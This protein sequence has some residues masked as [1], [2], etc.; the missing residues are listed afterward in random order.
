M[1]RHEKQIVST[2]VGSGF[3][4]GPVIEARDAFEKAL[5]LTVRTAPIPEHPADAANRL[6]E[7]L[8]SGGAVDISA[9]ALEITTAQQS[10]EAARLASEIRAC[11]VDAVGDRVVSVLR[12]EANAVHAAARARFDEVTS[13]ARKIALEL[14]AAGIGSIT[15]YAAVRDGSATVRRG[16]KRFEEELAREIVSCRDV[17][18][19]LARL[20][21][22]TIERDIDRVFECFRSPHLVQ[23]GGRIR[24]GG[25]L[26]PPPLSTDPKLS[27]WSSVTEFWSADPWLPTAQERDRRRDEVRRALLDDEDA[28]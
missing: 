9:T 1:E 16:A 11:V 10:I 18:A 3:A 25:R 20:T 6:A 4:T 15:E 7:A 19:K 13:E 23:A 26:R 24:R 21:G 14:Q 8:I 17:A 5:A 28:A 22:A 2:I 27:L 12:S